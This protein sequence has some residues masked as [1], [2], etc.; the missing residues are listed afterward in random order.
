MTRIREEEEVAGPMFWN[1]L[2]RNLRDPS[3]TAAVFGRSLKTFFSQ[4][5]SVHR[6]SEAFATMCYINWCFTYL[7]TYLFTVFQDLLD[8][9]T[10]VWQ[11]LNS[12][13]APLATIFTTEFICLLWKSLHSMLCMLW[14]L[15][16]IVTWHDKVVLFAENNN[17]SSTI[18]VLYAK[19]SIT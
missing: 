17:N 15:L 18:P 19:Q 8:C 10:S 14:S 4:S 9:H 7:L 12:F 1:S 11:F 16:V 3:H 5:T 2:P 13:W 6:A